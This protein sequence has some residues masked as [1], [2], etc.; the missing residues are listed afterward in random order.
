MVKD[1]T[2]H[3]WVEW[4]ED[5]FHSSRF[6][7]DSRASFADYG[8]GWCHS[9]L[10]LYQVTTFLAY[11]RS[12]DCFLLIPGHQTF[13]CLY[14]VIRGFL[15]YTRSSEDFLLIPGEARYS[16]QWPGCGGRFLGLY[17][18]EEQFLGRLRGWR[19]DERDSCLWYGSGQ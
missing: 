4:A 10:C 18:A 3:K 11:T 15:A 7:R 17:N 9:F 1:T 6:G 2:E 8:E 16:H 13:S 19:L 12:K 14:Q 5:F